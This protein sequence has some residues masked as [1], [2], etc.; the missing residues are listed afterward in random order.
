MAGKLGTFPPTTMADFMSKV[1]CCKLDEHALASCILILS[2]HDATSLE[3]AMLL[4][5][6]SAIKPVA[7]YFSLIGPV[8]VLS[9]GNFCQKHDRWSIIVSALAEF[10]SGEQCRVAVPIGI[11]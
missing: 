6:L 7:G 8:S 4:I 10:V 5:L 3:S 9:I 11:C 1:G 2:I